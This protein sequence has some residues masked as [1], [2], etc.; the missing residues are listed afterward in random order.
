MREKNKDR[1]KRETVR[2]EEKVG[3]KE[4]KN[5]EKKKVSLLSARTKGFLVY[6]GASYDQSLQP[7][8]GR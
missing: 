2:E 4:K 7:R 8:S 5:Q 3:E 1:K 6:Y